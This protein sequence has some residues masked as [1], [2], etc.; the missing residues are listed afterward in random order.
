MPQTTVTRDIRKSL[1]EA[2][3][4]HL[5][6]FAIFPGPAALNDIRRP[7]LV[8]VRERV[9][10]LPAA[11]MGAHLNT[12]TLWL[13]LPQNATEDTLDDRLET[14]FEALDAAR[15]AWTS[16]DRAVFE[17]AYPA[18][19]IAFTAHTTRMTKEA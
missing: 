2:L 8:L 13:V 12:L 4:P 11:P 10:P 15:I 3:K 6:G 17:N 1:S 7:S 5:R 9:E 14:L 16:A 19:Q 18:Y